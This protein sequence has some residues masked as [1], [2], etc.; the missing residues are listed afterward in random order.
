MNHLQ[1]HLLYAVYG[2]SFLWMAFTLWFH[3]R[4]WHSREMGDALYWLGLFA[5]LHAIRELLQQSLISGSHEL[6]E[7][8]WLVS[9]IS[10]IFNI[11]SYLALFRVAVWRFTPPWMLRI[12]F[13]FLLLLATPPLVLQ[14]DVSLLPVLDIGS[15]YFLALPGTLAASW[16]LIFQKGLPTFPGRERRYLQLG[17]GLFGI[18]GLLVLLGPQSDFFPA[19]RLHDTLFLQTF[20]FPV[21][22]LR[23]GLTL[24]LTVLLGR[25]FDFFNRL[26]EAHL[27][28]LAEDRSRSLSHLEERF[29]AL[30]EHSLEAIFVADARNGLLVEANPAACRLV[31]TPAED[32]LGRPM[33]VLHPLEEE[34]RA[35]EAFRKVAHQGQGYYTDLPVCNRF[36]VTV[37]VEI[38]ASCFRSGGQLLVQ[39]I[40]IDVSEQRRIQQVLVEKSEYLDRILHAARDLAILA[41]DMDLVVKFA[42]RT[43]EQMLEFS[44]QA[45]IKRHASLWQVSRLLSELVLA[46]HLEQARLHGE[47]G[48][49]LEIPRAGEMRHLEAHM[50]AI[51][52]RQGGMLG[53]LLLLRDVTERLQAQ[54]ELLLHRDHLDRLVRER[55]SSLE[56]ANRLLGEQQESLR[57]YASIVASSS[58][59]MSLLDRQLTYRA[60]N[61]AYLF[62]HGLEREEIVGHAVADILGETV[63]PCVQPSLMRCLEGETVSYQSWFTFRNSGRRWMDVT[64]NPFRGAWGQV[65]GVVVISRDATDRKLAEDAL[66]EMR[67]RFSLFMEHLPGVA[68]I[69]DGQGRFLFANPGFCEVVGR[70]E[71]NILG[72]VDE[73][74][75]PPE[76]LWSMRAHDLLVRS[77]GMPQQYTEVY[78]LKGQTSYWMCH[79]FPMAR[80]D[81]EVMLGGIGVNITSQI[82]AENRIRE[83]AKFPDENPHPVLRIGADGQVL[84][85]NRGGRDLL[86]TWRSRVGGTLAQEWRAPFDQALASGEMVRIETELTE[87][88]L[89]L[90]VVPFPDSG[91][92]NL[93]GMDITEMKHLLSLLRRRQEEVETLNVELERRVVEEVEKN[94]RKDMMLMQQSRL[95]AMGEMIGNIAHQWRQP[96][97]ALNL[98]LA[99]IEAAHGRGELHRT[100]LRDQVSMG[101]RVISGMS[102]TIDDFRNFF[103]PDRKPEVFNVADAVESALSMVGA[104]FANRQIHVVFQRPALPV[105]AFGFPNEFAQVVLVILSNA[106]DAIVA[107]NRPSG[108]VEI[109]LRNEKGR[110][111]TRLGDN[112]GGIG[113]EIIGRVFEPY[114]T[115]KGSGGTGIGLYMAK[116]IVEE[117]MSGCIEVENGP[118]GAQFRI[119]IPAGAITPDAPAT[120]P[121]NAPD[122]I[123]GVS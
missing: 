78:P 22:V 39:G 51:R 43:A 53:F 85:A 117:H 47:Y 60:V 106:K 41:C 12:P 109:D 95:A 42:N 36:G 84:Y 105:T 110:V 75:W 13:T 34:R 114:F 29:H 65:E 37:P 28:A 56:E 69:K 73:E 7:E 21:E 70:P 20:G 1:W 92:V 116:M 61:D 101:N 90:I 33:T 27:A 58:D 77:T 87:R 123:S 102:R 54:K 52:D 15:R 8:A 96:I 62:H 16:S 23:T 71:E 119:T 25:A 104:T 9:R 81:G 64:Y 3:A 118:R 74:L 38:S 88:V 50:V 46:P 57:Q 99:N 31:K 83:M 103:K 121:E 14:L 55:T 112:G 72:R 108:E 93:Y 111:V 63:F 100:L 18:Y 98:I 115:T 91:Y 120:G 4:Q 86:S 68:F 107:G 2:A 97:N 79:R 24:C 32:L 44:V 11:L 17:G 48:F 76:I 82:V 19:N 80:P 26:E 10:L 113:E 66:Q 49:Q 59:Q 5:F 35:R 40:F 45:C 67:Q 6:P 30:F 94:R 122:G 89:S